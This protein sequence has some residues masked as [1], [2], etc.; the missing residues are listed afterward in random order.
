MN[1][2]GL[3][4]LMLSP[5][6]AVLLLPALTSVGQQSLD[7]HMALTTAETSNL[8]LRAARQQRALGTPVQR[9]VSLW[10][11]IPKPGGKNAW[12]QSRLLSRQ[13]SPN[14][15]RKRRRQSPLR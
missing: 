1:L 13:C 10:T 12:T 7:V 4:R 8:E 14:R 3:P 11:C 15:T 6:V 9:A 2:G 5:V